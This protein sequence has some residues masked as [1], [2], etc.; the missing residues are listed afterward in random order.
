MVLPL[1]QLLSAAI[2][3][4]HA[5]AYAAARP[6]ASIR[7]SAPAEPAATESRQRG[8]PADAAVVVF[9]PGVAAGRGRALRGH[10]LH[11]A[12]RARAGGYRR[13]RAWHSRDRDRL[14]CELRP[15]HARR[16][17]AAQIGCGRRCR[18]WRRTR[19]GH[20]PSLTRR[21]REFRSARFGVILTTTH[22]RERRLFSG[23]PYG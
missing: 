10:C 12:W 19:Q 22:M 14:R 9:Q 15:H 5:A 4:D 2:A 3:V 8:R 7:R 11:Y 13:P 23:R 1:S 17:A 16:T 20:P 21:A 18:T 6:R